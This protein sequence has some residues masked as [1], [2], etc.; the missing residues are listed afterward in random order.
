MK[1]LTSLIAD[2]QKTRLRGWLVAAVLLLLIIALVS[3]Q[4]L[5]VVVYK[6]S[7]ISLASVLGYWL[8]RSLFPKARPG[9]YLKHDERLMAEGRWPVQTGLHLVFAAALL[10]R[11]L[12]VAAVCLAVAMGL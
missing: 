9:Q 10:R 5:P 12:I 11:A 1:K 3:P 4:Q 8:D 2:V 6:L 7:L